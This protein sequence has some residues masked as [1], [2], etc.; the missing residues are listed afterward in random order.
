MWCTVVAHQNVHAVPR[1]VLRSAIEYARADGALESEWRVAEASST[2]GDSLRLLREAL[3]HLASPERDQERLAVW[4]QMAAIRH[5]GEDISG[6]IDHLQSG[7]AIADRHKDARHQEAIHAMLGQLCLSQG[8]AETA[9][10]H[11]IR[12]LNLAEDQDNHLA[13]VT[14]ATLLCAMMIGEAD[15]TQASATASRLATSALARENW[16]AF[17]DAHLTQATCLFE[18]GEVAA[19]IQLLVG[20]TF[21]MANFATHAAVNLIKGRLVEMRHVIGGVDFDAHF[22]VAITQEKGG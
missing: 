14:H 2:T 21:R 5:D 10:P 7:L 22:E 12:A 1:R 9:R 17:A 16:L 13:V 8:Q 4:L 19:A 6:A 18:N 20:Q 11:L 3:T 15:W